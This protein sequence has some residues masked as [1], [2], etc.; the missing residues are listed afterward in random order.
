MERVV[1]T[2]MGVASPLGCHVEEFWS[3]L[4]AGCS[5]VVAL[6]DEQFDGLSTR[7]GGLVRGYQESDFFDRK[8]V[9]RMSRSSH[10]AVV[11]ATQAIQQAGL[12]SPQV[13]PSEIGVIIGSSIGG[14]AASDPMFRDFY[15]T[16]RVGPLTIPVS[17][18]MGPSAAV[19]IRF[20]YQGP[21]MNV[22]A[23]CASAAHAVGHVYHLIKAGVLDIALAGGADSAF[24]RGVV[25]AWAA[26][27]ALSERNDDPARACRPFSADRDGLVLGEG[28]GVLVL[29]SESSALRRGRP[30]LAEVKG[31]GA[32]SDS[33]HLTQ[34]TL[35]GP[36]HAMQ[37][38]LKDAGLQQDQIDY[39]NAHGTG[40]DWNDKNETAAIKAVFGEHAYR[41]PV[42]SNKSA[43]G[44]SIAASGGLEL[45]SC[46]QTLRDQK[47]SP[48]INYTTPDPLCDLDYVTDGARS[49][50]VDNIMTNSFAFGGSNAVLII[51]KYQ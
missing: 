47:V 3:N 50:K 16:G 44:H 28:A 29:E 10:L 9:R 12:D 17:M 45:V 14:Y 2:G 19:S 24:S 7:I 1:V 18:N 23:A 34:P 27:K 26:M 42:V 11:A 48:T 13:D 39:I 33:Y 15:L 5:G 38:A 49:L 6:T 25:A 37:K 22:D 32:S 51:S 30:I 41:L 8:E 21:L 31:Y 35:E 46:I 4:L 36:V 40:T 20:Q 43:L